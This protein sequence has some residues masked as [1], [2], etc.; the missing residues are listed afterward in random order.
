MELNIM[1]KKNGYAGKKILKQIKMRKVRKINIYIKEYIK[2]KKKKN[3]FQIYIQSRYFLY[4]I[5]LHLNIIIKILLL[6]K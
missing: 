3:I 5:I 6:L 2:P 4:I 1:E